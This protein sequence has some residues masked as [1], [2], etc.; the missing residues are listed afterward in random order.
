LFRFTVGGE[1]KGRRLA[2]DE[3]TRRH[4]DDRHTHTEH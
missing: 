2:E 3:K 1:T 4:A